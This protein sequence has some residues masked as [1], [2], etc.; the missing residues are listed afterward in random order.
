MQN[1]TAVDPLKHRKDWLGLVKATQT[2]KITSPT[3]NHDSLSSSIHC[4]NQRRH[5]IIAATLTTSRR[6]SNKNYKKKC[7]LARTCAPSCTCTCTYSSTS[8][9]L[10]YYP[11][12]SSNSPE[13]TELETP[14]SVQRIQRIHNR[15]QSASDQQKPKQSQPDLTVAP[16]LTGHPS[17]TCLQVM[18]GLS[19]KLRLFLLLLVIF[20]V[21]PF[22]GVL[23]IAPVSAAGTPSAPS[24][25]SQ[26]GS[27]SNNQRRHQLPPLQSPDVPFASRPSGTLKDK[28]TFNSKS[29]SYSASSSRH[30]ATSG[31]VFAAG[32]VRNTILPEF[33]QTIH[34][35]ATIDGRLVTPYKEV[36]EIKVFPDKSGK[37]FKYNI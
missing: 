8:S 24:P 12:A 30:S 14:E 5:T 20:V 2:D 13:T 3:D 7:A 28:L 35:K 23:I 21:S 37:I 1:K 10:P 36:N 26:S 19:H 27:S 9:I 34:S 15:F 17:P 11:I 16:N 25:F 18:V 31:N 32:S 4:V 29:S 22:P 6:C 33:L